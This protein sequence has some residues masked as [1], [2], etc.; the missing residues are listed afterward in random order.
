MDDAIRVCLRSGDTHGAQAA[1]TAAVKAQP[2]DSRH[3][4][5]LFQLLCVH[6]AWERALGQLDVIA[7]LDSQALPM[8]GTY[9][10]A[11][12]CEAVRAAVFAGR[13]TP[14]AFGEPRRWL[15]LLVEALHAQARGDAAGAMRLRDEA[16]GDAE[17]SAGT[18]NGEPFEWL[19]DA[20]ARIGPVLEAIVNGKYYWMPFGALAQVDIDPPEDLRDMVWLPAHFIF[21]NGGE[22]VGLIPTRYPGAESDA[23]GLVRLARKTSWTD[24][25]IGS[26]QRMFA[27]DNDDFPLLET[28]S[29]ILSPPP[30]AE[31]G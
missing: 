6:G 19:A 25:G 10:E 18:C 23:D 26:G 20:D 2:A 11:I 27:T 7:Q 28:R 31:E 30:L 8:V 16:L 13:A 5:A 17:A 15:A 1:A 21:A 14:L 9:R 12:K 22:T 3:R 24:D 29:I 4:I